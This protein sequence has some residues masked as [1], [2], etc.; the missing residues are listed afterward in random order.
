MSSPLF[1]PEGAQPT[2]S[3]MAR[4]SDGFE[5]T[6]TVSMCEELQATVVWKAIHCA[7]GHR[8]F[9]K[10]RQDRNLLM[11]LFEQGPKICQVRVVTFGDRRHCC[12]TLLR[13]N[14]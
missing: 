12:G 1:L 4:R 8:V 13:R 11:S 2:D 3:P 7:S 9:A 5:H 14:S 10:W 6:V